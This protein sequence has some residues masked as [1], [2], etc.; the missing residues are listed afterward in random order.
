MRYK[1]T[2]KKMKAKATIWRVKLPSF[3]NA[4]WV[5]LYLANSSIGVY[6]ILS[7]LSLN[8]NAQYESP[9]RANANPRRV[10]SNCLLSAII[11]AIDK[12]IGVILI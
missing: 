5:Q 2:Y 3:W 1:E 4:L 8:L 9:N 12:I 7:E 11:A 6:L 10:K